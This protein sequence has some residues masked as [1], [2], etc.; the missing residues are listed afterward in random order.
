MLNDKERIMVNMKNFMDS[1]KELLDSI[2]EFEDEDIEDINDIIAKKYPFH[3][4]LFE[5]LDDV[6]EW[7][8]DVED[9]LL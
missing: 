4:C 8:E 3:K 6:Y 7:Q 2:M 1:Y 9:R 5:L